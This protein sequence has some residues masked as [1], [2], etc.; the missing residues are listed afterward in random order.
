MNSL[1]SRETNPSVQARTCNLVAG[2]TE[3]G[4]SLRLT[5]HSPRQIGL[6]QKQNKNTQTNSKQ[7]GKAPKADL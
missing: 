5:G 7:L 2:E 1:K 4:G 3:M 6:S